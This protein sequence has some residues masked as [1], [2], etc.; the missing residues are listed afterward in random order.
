MSR[1]NLTGND[2]IDAKLYEQ[3]QE[4]DVFWIDSGSGMVEV[5]TLDLERAKRLSY[6]DTLYYKHGNNAD[7]SPGRYRVNGKP[8]TWKRSPERV[9][10]PVKRGL[11]ETGQVY[12]YQLNDFWVKK[13]K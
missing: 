11:Y 8:Q 12:E 2:E 7:G 3:N 10:V 5:V 6:K 9:R 4:L 1:I 13:E